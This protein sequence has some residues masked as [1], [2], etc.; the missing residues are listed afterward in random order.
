M[1]LVRLSIIFIMLLNLSACG[2]KAPEVVPAKKDFIVTVAPINKTSDAGYITKSAK[3]LGTSEITLTSLTAGRVIQITTKIGQNIGVNGRIAKLTDTAWSTKFGYQKSL[4]AIDSANNSY[5]VSKL[6]LEK[7]I[8][9]AKLNLDKNSVAYQNTISDAEKQ[10]EKL[11]RDNANNDLTN[12]DGTL[13]IQL[14]KL[15]KDLEKAKLDQSTKIK[16][17]DQTISNTILS[18]KN[19]YTDLNSLYQ[20]T[21]TLS[22]SILQPINVYNQRQWL[23][24]KDT[25]TKWSA[26]SA[27]DTFAWQWS[28]IKSIWNDINKDNLPTYL[29]NYKTY[30]SYINS[31]ITSLKNVISASV[32]AGITQTQLDTYNTQVTT[33]QTRA[34]GILSSITSQLNWSNSFVNT[35]ID[36][37]NSVAK[38][39]E[40]LESQIALTKKQLEDAAYA[41]QNWLDRTKIWLDTQINS[42]EINK[43]SAQNAYDFAVNTK[44]PNLDTINN[45]L[46][47]AQISLAENQFNMSKFDIKSPIKWIIA[48]IYIDLWQDVSPGTPIAKIVSQ[49]QEIEISLSETE[50]KYVRLGDDVT[51]VNS[52]WEWIG[53][54]TA[55]SPVADKNGNYKIIV[56]IFDDMFDIWS[57]VDVRIPLSDA[58]ISI[59]VNN[60]NILDNGYGSIILRDGSGFVNKSI[61]LGD[62]FGDSIRIQTDIPSKYQLVTSDI[63]NYDP[64]KMKIKINKMN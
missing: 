17:D 60:I 42:T 24:A 49:W 39:I 43:T 36:G 31:M 33:L 41:T 16:S 64:E 3:V 50:K 46:K 40:S 55:M 1:K 45:Q 27:F 20:D 32:A 2:T 18:A 15:Q 6:N 14:Q 28:K 9:D 38:Q 62:M 58:S 30:I 59:P 44:T 37:Q 19:I 51:I 54:I 4:A 12:T 25:S 61:K 34:S 35:Y 52:I 57:F 63:S 26:Y 21:Y 56:S 48:D 47:N 11:N 7:Q 53:K 29:D 13:Y 23:G 22:D 8:A 5:E 10:L